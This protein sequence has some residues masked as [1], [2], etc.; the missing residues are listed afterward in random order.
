[1]VTVVKRRQIYI[2]YFFLVSSNEIGKLNIAYMNT[3]LLCDRALLGLRLV[4]FPKM[5]SS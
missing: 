5:K 4:N 2:N 3:Q 1:M